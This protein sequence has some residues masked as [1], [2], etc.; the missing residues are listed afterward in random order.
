MQ[1]ALTA[2]GHNAQVRFDLPSVVGGAQSPQEVEQRCAVF[3]SSKAE[4]RQSFER[5]TISAEYGRTREIELENHAVVVQGQIPVRREIVKVGEAV[6][7]LFEPD[8]LVSQPLVLSREL[9]SM[10]V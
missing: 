4:Q 5:C 1:L 9:V 10:N 3:R 2:G 7:R 6:S 8:A